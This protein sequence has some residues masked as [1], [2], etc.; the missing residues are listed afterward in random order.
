MKNNSTQTSLFLAGILFLS[1]LFVFIYF[2]TRINN[3]NQGVLSAENK[4][5][6]EALKREEIK[7]LER[8]VKMID[9]EK[10]E[11][12]TH[13]AK[14]SDIVPFLDAIESFAPRAGVKAEV[15]SVDILEN[16]SGLSVGMNASGTF[17]GLYKFITLLENSPYEIIFDG[18]D[19]H[20]EGDREAAA[21]GVKDLKWNVFFKIKLLSF[22]E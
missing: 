3:N 6:L 15:T 1:S 2:Y 8:S 10:T 20:K 18:V 16:F 12:E 22:V 19:M 4:W 14:S 21:K 17:E 5:Q 7:T 11:L 9:L 13:F